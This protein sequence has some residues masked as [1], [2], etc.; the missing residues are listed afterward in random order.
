MVSSVSARN[1][2][3]VEKTS[4]L[5]QVFTARV[6][7]T[8]SLRAVFAA[9]ALSMKQKTATIKTLLPR[10][11]APIVDELFC[12]KCSLKQIEKALGHTRA[13]SIFS[14]A[15]VRLLSVFTASTFLNEQ[16]IGDDF[17]VF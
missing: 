16:S 4:R 17:S 8:A 5:A 6:I 13:F 2:I 15:A 7:Q 11:A 14:K 1:A 10:Q 9:M 12:V 3:A